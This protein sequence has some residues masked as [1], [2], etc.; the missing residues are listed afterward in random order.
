MYR[1]PQLVVEEDDKAYGHPEPHIVTKVA[2]HLSRSIKQQKRRDE[3]PDQSRCRRSS[4]R[5]Q[6]RHNDYRPQ[7]ECMSRKAQTTS[8]HPTFSRTF[9][10]QH[11]VS[12]LNC[13]SCTNQKEDAT[14]SIRLTKLCHKV[15]AM[16]STQPTLVSPKK[17]LQIA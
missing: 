8:S 1:G 17:L 5:H 16:H 14:Q 12:F 10:S 7:M 3:S 15:N 13:H 9:F 6:S 11:Q 4:T 2:H